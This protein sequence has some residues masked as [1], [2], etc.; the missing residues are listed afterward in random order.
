MG[1][2]ERKYKIVEMHR[3]YHGFYKVRFEIQEVWLLDFIPGRYCEEE[4]KQ[5]RTRDNGRKGKERKAIFCN[6]VPCGGTKH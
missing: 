2:K 1:Y 6:A 5:R 4:L 3:G